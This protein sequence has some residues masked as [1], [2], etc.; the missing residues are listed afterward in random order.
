[1]KLKALFLGMLIAGATALT[2]TA[3]ADNN[4]EQAID[5]TKIK[6]PPTNE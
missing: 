1:M 6:A 2:Y 3:I 4:A 5:K